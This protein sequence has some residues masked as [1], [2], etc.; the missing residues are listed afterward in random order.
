MEG[1]KNAFYHHATT[2]ICK[3]T[4]IGAGRPI[5][6]AC[7][8]GSASRTVSLL[9]SVSLSILYVQVHDCQL[10]NS[11]ADPAHPL[12]FRNLHSSAW[13]SWRRDLSPK[14]QTI[15]SKELFGSLG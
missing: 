11:I 3:G 7:T 2:G 5:S 6:N 15:Y 8:S 1:E 13:A 14:S 9:A 12:I 4:Q 10:K